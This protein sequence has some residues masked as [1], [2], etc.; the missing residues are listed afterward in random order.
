MTSIDIICEL[1]GKNPETP[2]QY[3][4]E[5]PGCNMAH[6][7]KIIGDGPKWTFNMDFVKPTFHPSLKVQYGPE[8]NRKICHSFVKDGNIQ[9][10]GD[11]THELKGK[12]VPLKPWDDS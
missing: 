12:T 4:F 6:S 9:F 11:C 8:H 1:H 10:L 2:I 7:I 3:G 5:C